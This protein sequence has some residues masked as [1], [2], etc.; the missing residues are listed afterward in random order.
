MK[1]DILTLENNHVLSSLFSDRH[2]SFLSSPIG[3]ALKYT[4]GKKEKKEK[5]EE[6]FNNS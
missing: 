4:S 5:K 1:M 6:E 3:P 2:Q